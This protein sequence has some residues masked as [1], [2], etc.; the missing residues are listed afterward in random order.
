MSFDRI[1]R[2][3]SEFSGKFATRLEEADRKAT[4][5][6]KSE[7]L[8]EEKRILKENMSEDPLGELARM[9]KEEKKD[10]KKGKMFRITGVSAV[11]QVFFRP[12][13]MPSIQAECERWWFSIS[14]S[15]REA[16][17]NEKLRRGGIRER[18]LRR[19]LKLEET[20][21][22]VDKTDD[23]EGIAECFA[24]A[25]KNESV[26]YW[27][28]LFMFAA[29][30]LF[31]TVNI[32]IQSGLLALAGF[33]LCLFILWQCRFIKVKRSMGLKYFCP[34]A[35]LFI[36]NAY[37]SEMAEKTDRTGSISAGNDKERHSDG[38]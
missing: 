8:E 18:I 23:M 35:V 4:E 36:Q 11:R 19:T 31:Y 2:R 7:I 13:V 29:M 22:K 10:G 1:K 26:R 17:I 3:V 38:K 21:A 9:I 5:R 34:F 27:P 37:I 24:E 12:A 33:V 32:P 25:V 30:V 6:K 28:V 15:K 14:Q 16:I 20:D